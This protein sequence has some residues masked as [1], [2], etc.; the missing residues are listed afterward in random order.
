MSWRRELDPNFILISVPLKGE[1][2]AED[3]AKDFFGTL[4]IDTS[5]CIRNAGT[6][7]DILEGLVAQLGN[8]E[9][10]SGHYP[11]T[12]LERVAGAFARLLAADTTDAEL[13]AAL[14][15]LKIKIGPEFHIDK[16]Q[17]FANSLTRHLL[18]KDVD[19][20]DC[21]KRT[22]DS[23]IAGPLLE[24][25]EALFRHIRSL[26]VDPGAAGAIPGA[27]HHKWPLAMNGKLLAYA[28]P[29]LETRNFTLER[30]IERAWVGSKCYLPIAV[31]VTMT[32]VQESK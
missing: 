20:F 6:A 13:E 4:K 17:H 26:W 30:Y 31:D 11:E 27:L 32:I 7:H 2:S 9:N 23:L 1:T 24:K 5:Q 18:L 15:A 14:L 28:D 21:F 12:P 29:Y 10:L 25:V 8:P 22:I 19:H 16:K 3:L